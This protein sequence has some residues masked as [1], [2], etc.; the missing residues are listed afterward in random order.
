MNIPTFAFSRSTTCPISRIIATLTLSPPLTD[1][2]AFSVVLPSGFEVDEAV[3]AG[4]STLLF[5]T[6][7]HGVDQGD[8][9][10]LELILVL[11]GK[12][13]SAINVLRS[14]VHYVLNAGCCGQG[15]P[16]W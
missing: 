11:L 14:A 4:V 2:I 3:N 13:A 16:A 8:G 15:F 10:P 6:I 12:S 5:A 7:R 1:T 9:P